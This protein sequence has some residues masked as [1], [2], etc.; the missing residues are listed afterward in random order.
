LDL[1]LLLKNA[2]FTLVVPGT[3]AVYVPLW[4]VTH[5]PPSASWRVWPAALLLTAGTLIYGWCLWDFAATGRG[6]PAPIDPPRALVV[7]G[8]YRVSRNPMYV[9]VLAIICGWAT[10]FGSLPIAGYAA[11]VAAAFHAFVRLYEEPHLARAFGESYARYRAEVAR[12]LPIR[13]RR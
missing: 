3:V 6:T 5:D 8:P 10:L 13:R 12:W 9:G 7:R 11:V 4:L 1:R 2:I